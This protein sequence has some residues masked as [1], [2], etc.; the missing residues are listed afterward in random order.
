MMSLKDVFA[1]FH[2]NYTSLHSSTIENISIDTR[3]LKKGD[4]FIAIKG[5][6]FDGHAFLSAAI[7]KGAC[8]AIV[9]HPIDNVTIP[10]V[11]V[12][13]TTLALGTLA[14]AWRKKFHSPVVALTGSCGK[15]TTKTILAHLL[16]KVAP[17]LSTEGTLNNAI[18]APLTLLKLKASHRYAVI[19]LGT[20]HVKEID[21]IANITQADIA[22]ITNIAPVHLEGFGTLEGIANEK[23][24][25]YRHLSKEGIALLNRDDAFF[26]YFQEVNKARTCF[27]FGI[28]AP[29]DIRA[30]DIESTDQGYSKFTLHYGKESAPIVLPLLGEYNVMN[31]LAAACA[32]YALSIPLAKVQEGLNSVTAPA[33]RM[34]HYRTQVGATLIDDS[35]NAN[36]KAFFAAI[37]FLSQQAGQKILVAGDMGELGP[38]APLFHEQVGRYAKEK[39]IDKLYAVGEL[40]AHTAHGFG[41]QGQ[42][43]TDKKEL[44]TYLQK[45]IK[46]DD[47]LLVKGSKSTRMGEVV[48]ELSKSSEG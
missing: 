20:N 37:D 36:P 14:Q 33:K 41:Q 17:T 1:L 7:E 4:L 19:E 21:Y 48:E 5:A 28:N 10:L 29:C 39:K 35:Y 47:I 22:L 38:E 31:A 43:F 6:N 16:S 9:D 2:Q 45:T 42:H 8:A 12:E 25:I 34:N 3:S 30:S 46:P 24:D 15:T 26:P 27:T 44:I 32:A 13:D 18:G 23:A 40:S 11:V